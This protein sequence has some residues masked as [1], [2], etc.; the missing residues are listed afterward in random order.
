M[1][2]VYETSFTYQA[3]MIGNLLTSAGIPSRVDGSYLQGIAGEIPVGNMVRVRVDPAHAVE[4]RAV[5]AE[6]ERA[7]V[8]SDE[9]AAA[10]AQAAGLDTGEPPV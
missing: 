6:W 5:I 3:Q 8:P 7:P 9:E 1:E 4:A 2:S 10:L